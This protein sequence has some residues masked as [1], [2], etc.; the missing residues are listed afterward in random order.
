[1]TVKFVSGFESIIDQKQPLRIL[2]SLLRNRKIPHALLFTGFE[3][4]GKAAVARI[5]AMACNCSTRK[6]EDVRETPDG[7]AP[8]LSSVDEKSEI[9]RDPSSPCGA[10][11]SCRKIETGNHP[12]IIRVKP[13]GPFIKIDQIRTLCRTLA[14]KPYEAR[15]RVVIISDAHTMNAPA[16][17]ALL[18]VLEEPP[19]QTI[20]VLTALHPSDL[21]PTVASRCQHIRFNP[22]SRNNLTAKL[23]DAAGLDPD[24]AAVITT[25]ANGSY[26][27]ALSMT[28]PGKRGNWI[29][30][31]RW[32]LGEVDALSSRPTRFQLAFA[33]RLAKDKEILPDSL[34]VI[35]T[36]LRDLVVAKYYPE[37]IINKDLTDKIQYA[38]QKT[39]VAS[40]LKKLKDIQTAQKDID[41]NANLRLAL[42]VLMVRLAGS[43]TD[44]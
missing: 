34:E 32:L 28:R 38:S 33:A 24:D 31:R 10:C 26:A 37:K 15:L 14:M 2:S 35:K 41:A 5:F 21:L 30:R 8:R 17:N 42:E 23:V 27:K 3:G 20:L 44:A 39:S 18:K 11:K 19:D 1:L 12:D 16:G 4:V 36:Y 7:Q 43:N 22:I 40:L 29:E 13:S 25:M 6:A 9:Y